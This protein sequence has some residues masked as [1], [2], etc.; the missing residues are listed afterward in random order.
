[1][2]RSAEFKTLPEDLAKL[3]YE[4]MKFTKDTSDI[5][6][7]H[8]TAGSNTGGSSVYEILANGYTLALEADGWPVFELETDNGYYFFIGSENRIK[9][10]LESHLAILKEP[11]E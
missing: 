1:M 6:A 9:S 2:G 7:M 3:F 11:K 8:C 5:A 10:E 4:I